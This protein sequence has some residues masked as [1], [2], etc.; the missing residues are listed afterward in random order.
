MSTATAKPIHGAPVPLWQQ[1]GLQPVPPVPCGLKLGDTVT[2]T[3]DAG[4]KFPGKR[5]IGFGRTVNGMEP[6]TN[7]PRPGLVGHFVYIDTDAHWFPHRPDE[8]TLT[9]SST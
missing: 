7:H 6:T 8:L 2:F 3:N 9:H 4:L 1:R 5:I